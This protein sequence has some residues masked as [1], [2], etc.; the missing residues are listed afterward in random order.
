MKRNNFARFS[1]ILELTMMRLPWAIYAYEFHCDLLE[2][3]RGIMGA[4]FI[5]RKVLHV[6]TSFTTIGTH[7][8]KH[9]PLTSIVCSQHVL[10]THFRDIGARFFVLSPIQLPMLFH[11]HCESLLFAQGAVISTSSFFF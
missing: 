3:G 9:L 5:E 2:F 1:Y 11:L 7:Q 10:I 6:A 8:R 4:R